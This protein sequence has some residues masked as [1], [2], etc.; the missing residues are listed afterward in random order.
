MKILI[1]C[2][3]RVQI[4]I[5]VKYKKLI[6]MVMLLTQIFMLM[7]MIITKIELSLVMGAII[8]KKK[9]TSIG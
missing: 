1:L 3:Q 6:N 2:T 9:K 8:S 4:I 5:V 7:Q